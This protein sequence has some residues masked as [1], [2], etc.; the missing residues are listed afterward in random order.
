MPKK[1]IGSYGQIIRNYQQRP[2]QKASIRN[3]TTTKPDSED[4]SLP[5][6]TDDDARI[7]DLQNELEKARIERSEAI[8]LLSSQLDHSNEIEHRYDTLL[9]RS[10]S[11]DTVK[12]KHHVLEIIIESDSSSDEPDQKTFVVPT[13]RRTQSETQKVS[14]QAVTKPPIVPKRKP[15]TNPTQPIPKLIL[16]PYQAQ[17]PVKQMTRAEMAQQKAID[18]LR[19]ANSPIKP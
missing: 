7:R 2:I 6:K 19:N 11:C 8:E 14:R 17:E 18:R 4:K 15:V 13:P 9:K 16:E 10:I 1:R 5:V 12:K 3:T